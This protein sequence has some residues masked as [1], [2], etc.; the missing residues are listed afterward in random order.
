MVGYLHQWQSLRPLLKRLAVHAEAEAARHGGEERCLPRALEQ[1]Y[2]AAY[3]LRLLVEALGNKRTEPRAFL[4]GIERKHR[5]A[6]RRIAVEGEQT[7]V[8]AEHLLR[9]C[10]LHLRQVVATFGHNVG[11]HHRCHV[12]DHVVVRRIGVVAMQKP[13]GRA[14]VNLHIAH[15]HHAVDAHLGIEE[16]RSGVHVQQPRVDNLHAATVGGAQLAER[17]YAMFPDIVQ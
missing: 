17:Q 10:E 12:Q 4:D 7:A 11:I 15:P 6:A 8:V 3:R 13:V 5:L 9:H 14:F 16:I 2:A 1:S